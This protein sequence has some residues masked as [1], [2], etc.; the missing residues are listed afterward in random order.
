[1]RKRLA[2]L[3]VLTM[4]PGLSASPPLIAA[5]TGSGGGPTGSSCCKV[6]TSG[7]ACGDTRFARNKVCSTAGACA[8]DG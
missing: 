1:M 3:S 2:R 7:E 5:C 4:A 6:Y 8:C